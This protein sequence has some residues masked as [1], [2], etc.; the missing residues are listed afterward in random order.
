MST[1]LDRI[2]TYKLDEIAARKAARPIAIV[3]EAARAAPAPRGF[4]RALQ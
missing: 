4:A 2:R 1:I 3:D